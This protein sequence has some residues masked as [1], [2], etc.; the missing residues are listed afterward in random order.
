M[1]DEIK[2]DE[3]SQDILA[4]G[5]RPDDG[6]GEPSAPIPTDRAAAAHREIMQALR[7]HGCRIVPA[8]Q[9]ESIG[10]PAADGLATKAA[11]FAVWGVQAE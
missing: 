6:V 4:N 8:L 9:I 2:T 3:K 11:V 1:T 7:R 10:A 5:L